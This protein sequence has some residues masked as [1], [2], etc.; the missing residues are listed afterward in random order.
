MD[1]ELDEEEVDEFQSLC[2]PVSSD[3]S[4]LIKSGLASVASPGS[5]GQQESATP[6]MVEEQQEGRF[7]QEPLNVAEGIAVL[8]KS[9]ELGVPDV[10]TQ[11]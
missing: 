3:E 10:I 6:M 1:Q 8:E 2:P 5:D 4:R 9:V 7:H 11:I